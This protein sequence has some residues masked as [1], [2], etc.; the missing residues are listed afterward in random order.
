MAFLIW[1]RGCIA[2]VRKSESP[3]ESIDRCP[4]AIDYARYQIPGEFRLP[5]PRLLALTLLMVAHAAAQGGVPHKMN[6]P[7]DDEI[8]GTGVSGAV[9]I[10]PATQPEKPI[11]Q[12]V[13]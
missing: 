10:S 7:G 1:S 8:A 12:K 11:P 6:G 5:I 2:Q 3:E 9:S 13:I 4:T